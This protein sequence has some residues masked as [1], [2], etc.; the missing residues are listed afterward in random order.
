MR[1]EAGSGSH[2]ESAFPARRVGAISHKLRSWSLCDSQTCATPKEGKRC[3]SWNS[4]TAKAGQVSHESTII[5]LIK[6]AVRRLP[7]LG[8]H[9]EIIFIEGHS[10]DHTWA[11]IERV[12]TQYPDLDIKTMRQTGKGKGN[13]VREAFEAASGEILMILDADLT[14]SPEELVKF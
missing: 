13:A 6:V 2:D 4:G 1:I 10:T 14:V 11:E 3:K 5:S 12:K 9:T 7:R 8:K